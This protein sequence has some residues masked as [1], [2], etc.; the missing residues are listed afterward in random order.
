MYTRNRVHFFFTAIGLLAF[1][2]SAAPAQEKRFDNTLSLLTTIKT[3]KGFDRTKPVT[4]EQIQQILAAGNNAPSAMNKQP[5]FFSAVINGKLCDEIAAAGQQ[6]KDNPGN[7]Q[8]AADKKQKQGK[9]APSPAG[10]S[11]EREALDN[12]PAVIV[13]SGTKEWKWSAIDC[14]IACEA[15]SIAAQSMGLGTHI[16]AGPA[17][18]LTAPSRAELR[19]KLGIP[20]DKE[21]LLILLVGYPSAEN[22]DTVS[23]ASSRVNENSLILK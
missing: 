7:N 1:F 20:Q 5:W 2:A 12:A 8:P 16:V 23:H 10:S 19:N 6:F 13:V 4:E 22:P 18:A 15:M 3:T 21:P 17:E 14:S 9:P 11:D